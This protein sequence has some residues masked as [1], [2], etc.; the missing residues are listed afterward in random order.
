MY[1]FYIDYFES[2]FDIVAARARPDLLRPSISGVTTAPADPAMRG[3]ADPRGA[4]EGRQGVW[5]PSRISN[6]PLGRPKSFWGR[7]KGAL[8]FRGRALRVPSTIWWGRPESV[9]KASMKE[10]K[11]YFV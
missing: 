5:A 3:G 4:P 11:K 9:T 6:S 2:G 7:P 10:L 1:T 8:A